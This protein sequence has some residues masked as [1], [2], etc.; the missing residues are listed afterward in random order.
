MANSDDS[1]SQMIGG[2]SHSS[3]SIPIF[4]NEEHGDSS[5]DL[6]MDAVLKYTCEDYISVIRRSIDHITSIPLRPKFSV[7]F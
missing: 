7:K 4:N 3:A 6:A 5:A 2:G 1:F